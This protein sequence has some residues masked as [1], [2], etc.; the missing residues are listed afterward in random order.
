MNQKEFAKAALDENPKI[1]VVSV[2][3]LSLRLKM[4]IH[5]A[6]KAQ[7]A[8]LFAKKVTVLAKYTNFTNVFIIT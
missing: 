8:L 1:F 7:I 2:S 3:F 5:L 6:W 4:T